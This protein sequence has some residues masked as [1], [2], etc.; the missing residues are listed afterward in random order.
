MHGPEA[1]GHWAATATAPNC[2]PSYDFLSAGNWYRV[3]RE[4][5]DASGDRHPVGETWRFVGTAYMHY[6]DVRGFCVSLD[7][8]GEWLF[9][10]MGDP[11]GGVLVMRDLDQYIEAVAGP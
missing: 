4:F 6:D 3:K 9:H 8:E 2:T 5:T 7:G 11:A 10:L 1:K